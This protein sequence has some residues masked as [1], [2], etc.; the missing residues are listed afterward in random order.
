M[1]DILLTFKVI[2]RHCVK[3]K[4]DSNVSYR[5]NF[6]EENIEQTALIRVGLPGSFH[7]GLSSSGGIHALIA[8][9]N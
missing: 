4:R 6:N 8:T 5:P 9:A 1:S 7:G 3:I 2:A